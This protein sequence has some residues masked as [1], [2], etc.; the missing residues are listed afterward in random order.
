MAADTD[1]INKK[2]DEKTSFGA[3]IVK[4]MKIQAMLWGGVVLG[5]TAGYFASK[6]PAIA[7]AVRRAI[8]WGAGLFK[9]ETAEI[10]SRVAEHH[11][12]KVLT[13]LGVMA[14]SFAGAIPNT[15]EH[16]REGKKAQLRVE[17]MTQDV[18]ALREQRNAAMT[19]L[20]AQAAA[21]ERQNS[22]IQEILAQGPKSRESMI[23][24]SPT[25][26]QV[27]RI[28]RSQQASEPLQRS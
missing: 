27:Q 3:Y 5:G 8:T 1:D 11:T 10:V 24:E 12:G 7:N 17:E 14:G 9:N 4:D 2:V 25:E 26:G 16:W 13:G 15:Y 20:R 21:I 22:A 23:T 19:E 18:V 28:E 6:S